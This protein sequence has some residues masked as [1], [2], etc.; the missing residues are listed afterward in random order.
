MHSIESASIFSRS[1]SLYDLIVENN[2]LCHSEI[3]TAVG[4]IIKSRGVLGDYRLLDLGCGNVRYLARSLKQAPPALYEG[5]D[6][7]LTALDEARIYLKDINCK[8]ILTHGDLLQAVESTEKKWDILFA[9]FA[10]HHLSL[11]EKERF[12][13]AVGRCLSQDGWLLMVDVIRMENQERADYIDSYLSMMR[14][15]WKNIPQDQLEEICAHV[16]DYDFP[17]C[18][19]TLKEMAGDAGLNVAQVVNCYKQHCTILFSGTALSLANY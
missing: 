1:W 11:Q 4:A 17:E 6:L 7:S 8:V 10:V 13:R 15:H 19:T 14:A 9:G 3:Y 2:Y 16:R 18:L 5:V 12:F